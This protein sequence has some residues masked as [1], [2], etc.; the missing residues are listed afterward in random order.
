MRIGTDLTFLTNAFS[1]IF[2]I[3]F[4]FCPFFYKIVLS[5]DSRDARWMLSLPRY[6]LSY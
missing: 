4:P 2:N 3:N 5:A 6:S 1:S